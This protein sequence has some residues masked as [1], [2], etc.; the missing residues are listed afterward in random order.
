M[1]CAQYRGAG[2]GSSLGKSCQLNNDGILKITQKYDLLKLGSHSLL[3][4][5]LNIKDLKKIIQQTY[6]LTKRK[7]YNRKLKRKDLHL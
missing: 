6:I 1:G 5:T 4:S 3:K 7:M 2:D